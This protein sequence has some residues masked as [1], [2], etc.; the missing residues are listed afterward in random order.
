MNAMTNEV[1]VQF[2]GI[3]PGDL[4]FVLNSWMKSLQP[5]RRVG[6]ELFFAG[7]QRLI[8]ALAERAII[9]V[10]CDGNPL[11]SHF[12]FGWACGEMDVKNDILTLH[13]IYVKHGYRMMG[14]AKDMLAKLGWK[15]KTE[16]VAT[17]WTKP[18]A[19]LAQRYNA[20]FSDYPLM[21]G[22]QNV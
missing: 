15:P 13:Y 11:M 6:N 8:A 19:V 2:R 9:I 17:H 18:C 7:Q 22:N 4:H 21:I 1:T 20:R 10:C 14:L 3:E 16:I 5:T 12:I